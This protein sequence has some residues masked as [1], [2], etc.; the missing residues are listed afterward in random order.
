L[1]PQKDWAVNEPAELATVLSALEG[2]QRDF[3]DGRS[4]G[5][6]ISLADLIVLAGGAAVEQAAK[7]GGVDVSVRFSPG[8]TDAS[9]EQTDV[10][11]FDVLEPRADGFRNYIQVG[12]KLTPETLLLDRANLLNLT[13]S[14]LVVL[15]GG[16]RALGTNH[17]GSAHGV[18][19]NRP[20]VLTNDVF[21]NLLDMA[22]EWST[23][24]TEHVYDG[25]DRATGEQRWTATA[26]DLVLGSHAVLRGIAEVYGA[27]DAS[28]K[29]VKDFAAAWAKVMELDRFDLH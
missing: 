6:R 4:D 14:E 7:E 25:K 17:D 2:I 23:S 13:P 15:V 18:L 19:T 27:A 22:T 16:M 11:T 28:E 26:A 10:D 9:Q 5:V 8:R 21:V 12:E 1:A 24:S 20:G 3:N 29:F